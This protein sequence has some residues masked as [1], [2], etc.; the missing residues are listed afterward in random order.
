MMSAIGVGAAIGG[1]AIAGLGHRFPRRTLVYSGPLL[2]GAA[3]VALVFAPTFEFA[4]ACLVAAGFAMIVLG[5]SAQTKVQEDV[6]DALRGRVMAVYSLVFSA[7]MPAGGLLIGFMAERIGPMPSIAIDAVVCM[8]V[9]VLLF[10]WSQ[11]ERAD[12]LRHLPAP[13]SKAA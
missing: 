3:F 10:T 12:Q 5:V 8:I 1:L 9:T 13:S 11:R 7:L 6:S 2:C 4:L